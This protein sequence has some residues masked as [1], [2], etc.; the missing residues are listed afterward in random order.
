MAQSISW[1]VLALIHLLPAIAF[2]RPATLTRLYGIEA[3]SS[4]FLLMRHR[5]ALF[6]GIFL[7]CIWASIAPE[8]RP[9]AASLTALSMLSFL[10]LYWCAGRPHFVR[11]IA[12]ADLIGLPFLICVLWGAFLPS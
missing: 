7:T 2:F 11:S 9:L 5:A 10:L 4:V 8:V 1:I 3:S 12:L 6:L